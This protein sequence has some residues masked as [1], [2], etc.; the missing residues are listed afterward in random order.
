MS[1]DDPRVLAAR[2]KAFLLYEGRVTPH[3]SCGIAMAETFGLGTRPYQALRR[4]GLT[5][6]GECGVIV[7][8]RLILGEILGDPD[9]SGPPTPA[10]KQAIALFNA[11]WPER[12]QRGAA[13][14]ESM[15]C[16]TLTAPFEDFRGPAR[17]G[18]CAALATE[19]AT[20]VAEVLLELGV[21]PT[22]DPIEGVAGFD[23]AAPVDP[24]P[25]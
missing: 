13:E 16:N 25:R 6:E 2:Q 18:F 7:S 24:L 23:P 20:V 9:P 11:R 21:E 22:V 10:L 12:V 14:G 4:G 19:V 1:T 3:R 5:G 8:G 17:A 15:I